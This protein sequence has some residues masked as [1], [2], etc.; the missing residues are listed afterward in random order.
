MFADATSHVKS[1]TE[2][3]RLYSRFLPAD[4]QK[5]MCVGTDT[6]REGAAQ[7]W[8]YVLEC[9]TTEH[10]GDENGTRGIN[11]LHGISTTHKKYYVGYCG[12]QRKREGKQVA[13]YVERWCEHLSGTAIRD[14][15]KETRYKVWRHYPIG[16]THMLPLWIG[17]CG[18]AYAREQHIIRAYQ[19]PTNG[20]R[21]KSKYKSALQPNIKKR[22]AG[23]SGIDPSQHNTACIST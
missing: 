9:V 21:R 7:A 6:Q 16:T 23:G 2:Y 3:W 11:Y 18:E 5:V 17:K 4:V 1:R 15:G 8:L 12:L 14:D 13:G 10:S 22:Q 20:P 19:S